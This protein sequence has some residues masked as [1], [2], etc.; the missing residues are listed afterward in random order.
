MHQGMGLGIT[1]GRLES[2]Y[3]PHQSLELRNLPAG[4]VEARI[5]LPFHTQA[6][7]ISNRRE[8]HVEL[9]STDR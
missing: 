6:S 5:T 2:L 9:Q 8:D 1:R 3:G 7:G 4:G